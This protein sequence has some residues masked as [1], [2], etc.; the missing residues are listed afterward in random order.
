MKKLPL[1][2]FIAPILFA[3][4]TS[5]SMPNLQRNTADTGNL[6]NAGKVW[7]ALY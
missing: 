6:V 2:F 3:F 7:A 4:K 5:G 1:L